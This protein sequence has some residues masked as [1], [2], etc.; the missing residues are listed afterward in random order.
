MFF[1]R[2]KKSENAALFKSEPLL[3][4]LNSYSDVKKCWK[5][6]YKNY[7]NSM[8]MLMFASEE[9]PW[10]LS[11]RY[12]SSTYVP[13]DTKG[14]LIADPDRSNPTRSRTERPLQTI[15]GFEEAIYKNTL[16]YQN[17]FYT[18]DRYMSRR[19]IRNYSMSSS[20]APTYSSTSNDMDDLTT[21]FGS[22]MSTDASSTSK[23]YNND[24]FANLKSIKY[25]L[26]IICRYFQYQDN[27]DKPHSRT[28]SS[29]YTNVYNGD[30]GKNYYSNSK[31]RSSP[32]M[33]HLTYSLNDKY[34]NLCE[35]GQYGSV[36]STIPNDLMDTKTRRSPRNEIQR[37]FSEKIDHKHKN[38]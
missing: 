38:R 9:E 27:Y 14:Y 35:Y 20:D 17:N 24:R 19:P 31:Y 26:T 18:Q 37:F 5:Q 36:H 2:K 25:Y 34:K 16:G 15:M 4:E 33:N 10:E 21:D 28:S 6:S 12:F 29:S 23:R 30:S 1:K 13:R 32:V 22:S 7:E 11:Q 8:K 3:P